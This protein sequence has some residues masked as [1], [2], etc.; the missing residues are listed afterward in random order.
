MR[1]RAAKD[2]QTSGT[3][4]RQHAL[5]AR[6]GK[7]ASYIQRSQRTS[8]ADLITHKV[9]ASGLFN[10]SFPRKR[11][12]T[13]IKGPWIPAFAGMT[14]LHGACARV[15]IDPRSQWALY[16]IRKTE[17]IMAAGKSGL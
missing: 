8:N 7:S 14:G 4:I 3:E 11:E 6:M 10:S 2:G 17:A 12:S 13:S 1:V 15:F 9:Q 5:L 16:V